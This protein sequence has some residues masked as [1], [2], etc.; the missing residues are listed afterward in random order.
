MEILNI[1]AGICSMISVIGLA[2]VIYQ[3]GD[4]KKKTEECLKAL[5]AAK[6]YDHLIRLIQFQV[7]KSNDNLKKAGY[8]FEEAKI[9]NGFTPAVCEKT[10]ELIL[11]NEDLRADIEKDLP[12]CGSLLSSANDS[13]RNSIN[14][15]FWEKAKSI[16]QKDIWR[17]VIVCFLRGKD[18]SR[19]RGGVYSNNFLAVSNNK[20]A[21]GLTFGMREEISPSSR[22]AT[23]TEY[24]RQLRER[25]REQHS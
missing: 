24:F 13:L 23:C 16:L 14:D 15:R 11:A 5:Q 1:I 4:A 19:M 18:P 17:S 3:I 6:D 25:H 22:S 2:V 10:R 9:S 7:E 12:E 21:S 8:I 20:G